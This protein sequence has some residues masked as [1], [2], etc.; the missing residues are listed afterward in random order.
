MS[1]LQPTKFIVDK[2]KVVYSL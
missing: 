1:H 2:L